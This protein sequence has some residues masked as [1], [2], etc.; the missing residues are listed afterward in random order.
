[1]GKFE[2]ANDQEFGAETIANNKIDSKKDIFE[3]IIN[4]HEEIENKAEKEGI[5]K[6]IKGAGLNSEIGSLDDLRKLAAEGTTMIGGYGC[7][8]DF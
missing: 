5:L 8:S 3:Q 7:N 2:N 4:S 6:K 1:M